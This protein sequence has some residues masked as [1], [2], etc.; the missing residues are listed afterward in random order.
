MSEP[1]DVVVLGAGM[2]GTAT[3]VYLRRAGLSTVLMDRRGAG[4]ETSY[5][6]AGF[7]QREALHPYLMPRNLLRLL[8]YG[9]NRSTDVHYHPASLLHVAPFLVRY[10]M[11]SD[12]ASARRTFEANIPIFARCLETHEEL[13]RAAGAEG[14]IARKGWIRLFRHEQSVKARQGQIDDLAEQGIDAGFVEADALKEL[15]PDVDQRV[16]AGAIHYRAPWTTNDPGAL[17]K[18]YCGLFEAEGGRFV[19]GDAM[20]ARREGGRWRIDAADG[21]V[22]EATRIVV[23]LGPWS[24]TFLKRLGQSV[25]LGVKRGYHRHYRPQGTAS[26]SRPVTDDDSGFALAPMRQGIRLTTGA[27]FALRDA[28][29]TPVQLARDLPRAR[30]LFP[31]GEAVEPEPWMGARPVL[32]DMLPAI[33]RAPGLDDVWLNFGHAHHGLTL[34]P[35]TGLLLSQM[36]SGATCYCD[37]APYDAKRFTGG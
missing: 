4:E 35:A 16:V 23:A 36:M 34:G 28:P 20:S 30:E 14:L 22:V 19:R 24:G 26:L 3:A 37:P 32:P 17:T 15:E 21:S 10:W 1:L 25:P 31:L 2:V 6:N 12:S 8:R 33:G 13:A 11:N 7:I 27:E 9:L 18:A 5:G 29:K